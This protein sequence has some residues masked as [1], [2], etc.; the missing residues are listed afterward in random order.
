MQCSFSSSSSFFLQSSDDL[1]ARKSNRDCCRLLNFLKLFKDRLEDLSWAAAERKSSL[2]F[3]SC[4]KKRNKS[5]SRSARAFSQ[6]TLKPVNEAIIYVYKR[7][8]AEAAGIG[9]SNH[10]NRP[11]KYSPASSSRFSSDDLRKGFA[12][13]GSGAGIKQ[14]IC[15][16]RVSSALF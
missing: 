8:H 14:C 13:W 10:P 11:S 5:L 12:K 6:F 7:G 15:S 16:A 4:W 1:I 9:S 3:Y 2:S